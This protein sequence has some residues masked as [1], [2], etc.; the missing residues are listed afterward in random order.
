MTARAVTARQRSASPTRRALEILRCRGATA[1][2]VEHW[3]AHA[4]RRVDLFGVIDIVAIEP[5]QRGVLGIQ[6]TDA[7]SVSKRVTKAQ[8]EPR[9]RAW[10]AAGNRF[11]V[12]GFP[13]VARDRK[14]YDLRV[15]SLVPK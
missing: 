8:A 4:R 5:G 7:S 1:Q 14:G 11:E 6:A 10:L 15:V 2:V 13:T 3:N 12:W 9:L